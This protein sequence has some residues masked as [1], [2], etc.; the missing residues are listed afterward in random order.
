MSG[1]KDAAMLNSTVIERTNH[2]CNVE[3]YFHQVEMEHG[4]ISLIVE[5]Y[6]GTKFIASEREGNNAAE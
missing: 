6:N 4:R 2:D 3:F 5:T 1:R